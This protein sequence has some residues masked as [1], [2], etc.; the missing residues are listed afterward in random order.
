MYFLNLSLGQFLAMFGAVSAVMI[1]LYL[2][3]NLACLRALGVTALAATLTPASDVLQKAA[4]PLGAKF[5]LRERLSVTRWVGIVLIYRGSGVVNFAHGTF[6]LAGAVM[7]AELRA[8]NVPLGLA[9]AATI[10]AGLVL[11]LLVQNVIMRR[12][13]EAAPIP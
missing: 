13:R 5:L 8:R 7:F 12:L 2:L 6:A 10:A 3:V 11:G 4:G 9:F 1:A